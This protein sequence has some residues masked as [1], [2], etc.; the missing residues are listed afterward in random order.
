M[1]VVYD[2]PKSS[3]TNSI[4]SLTEE[5]QKLID[6]TASVSPETWFALSRWA[7]ETNNF[8]PWL[9]SMLFSVG[10]LTGRGRKPSIK[11]SR[12][13]MKALKEAKEKGFT[14]E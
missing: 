1:E 2:T 14:A 3:P 7:K 10:S 9:R 6:E 4:E 11:Q 5:D 13:A 8:Q 12:Y